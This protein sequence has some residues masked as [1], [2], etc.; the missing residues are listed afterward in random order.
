MLIHLLIA[1]SVDIERSFSRGRLTVSKLRH[2]LSGEST[3]AAT[4]LSAWLK[5]PGLVPQEKIVA[6][7]RDKA[8]RKKGDG[9]PEVI[10]VDDL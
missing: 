4:V 3:C 2:N 10:V 1:T 7:F 6:R 9:K 8:K 5:V